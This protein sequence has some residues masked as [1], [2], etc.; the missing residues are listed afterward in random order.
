MCDDDGAS[1]NDS[2]SD[3]CSNELE[4]CACLWAKLNNMQNSRAYHARLTR[5]GLVEQTKFIK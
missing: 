4:N 2:T 5:N 3:E 1:C